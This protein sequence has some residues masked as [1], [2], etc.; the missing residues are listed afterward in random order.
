MKPSLSNNRI[1]IS[2][3]ARLDQILEMFA[4]LLVNYGLLFWGRD[5]SCAQRVRGHRDC[6]VLHWVPISTLTGGLSCN[7]DAESVADRRAC[8]SGKH[9]GIINKTSRSSIGRETRQ[10]HTPSC[11]SSQRPGSLA[12]YPSSYHTTFRLA[13]EAQP[14]SRDASSVR[15]YLSDA[16]SGP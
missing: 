12:I 9:S 8:T 2:I 1:F 11:L 3:P 4:G 14:F 16:R 6:V 15:Q 7:Y 5:L 13:P 10:K